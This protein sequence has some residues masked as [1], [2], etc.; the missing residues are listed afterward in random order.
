[1]VTKKGRQGGIA[2]LKGKD[3]GK[4]ETGKNPS[5]AKQGSTKSKGEAKYIGY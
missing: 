2:E 5:I 4:G 1:M 3:G